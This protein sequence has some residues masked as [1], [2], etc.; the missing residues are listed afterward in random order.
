[1]DQVVQAE[2]LPLKGETVYGRDLQYIPGGKGANQAVAMA[3]LGADVRMFGKV[4]DD[5]NGEVMLRTLEENGVDISNIE[6]TNKAP[7]GL[8]IIAVGERDNTIIIVAGANGQVDEDYIKRV[9]D[10]LL[11]SDLVVLQHE[12]PQKTNEYVA[13]LC[14]KNGIRVILNPAPARE[15]SEAMIEN[16]DFITPNEHEVRIIFGDRE[17]EP[18]LEAYGGKLIV[19][20]GSEGVLAYDGELVEVPCRESRVVDTTGAGDT[21]NAAFTVMLSEGKGIREALEF[22]NTAA[23]L[24]TETL[25]AQGGMPTR[26]AVEQELEKR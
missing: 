2:R 17:L 12:I 18:L 9:E 22:A 23:G 6:I 25:G 14:R 10:K 15:L 4:G 8:A 24:S 16:V 21:M 19:T 11:E 7:T 1:M 13:K 5:P 20:R 3:R 26:K